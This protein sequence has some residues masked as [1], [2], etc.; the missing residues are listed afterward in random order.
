MRSVYGQ[1]EPVSD[2]DPAGQTLGLTVSVEVPQVAST[3]H[4]LASSEKSVGKDAPTH[5]AHLT[6]WFR[7]VAH[8]CQWCIHFVYHEPNLVE[9]RLLLPCWLCRWLLW[10]L[11]SPHPSD[12]L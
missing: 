1:A 11:L 9:K 8:W 10:L 12:L 4:V 7:D 2:S 5:K 3:V 6:A